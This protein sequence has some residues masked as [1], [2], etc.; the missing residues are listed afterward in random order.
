MQGSKGPRWPVGRQRGVSCW[1]PQLG[2][3]G[4]GNSHPIQN[5]SGPPIGLAGYSYG[6]LNVAMDRLWRGRFDMRRREFITRL[7]GAAIGWPIETRAQRPASQLSDSWARG[8]LL[9][10]KLREFSVW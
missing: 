10:C 7:G 1:A 8:R 2:D 5:N 6:R 9:S 3:G 4:A